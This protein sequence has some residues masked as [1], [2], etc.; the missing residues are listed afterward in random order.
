MVYGSNPTDYI[1]F[2][3]EEDYSSLKKLLLFIFGVFSTHKKRMAP[4][5]VFK[6]PSYMK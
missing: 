3:T 2:F 1:L 4:P 6:M 5:L